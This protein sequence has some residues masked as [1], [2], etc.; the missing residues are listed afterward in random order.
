MS[1]PILLI[2]FD[3][4]NLTEEQVETVKFWALAAAE[5]RD[6]AGDGTDR[7]PVPAV[8]AQ[9]EL[10]GPSFVAVDPAGQASS[11]RLV[12]TGG[13][14]VPPARNPQVRAQRLA[15]LRDA[16]L[17][18]PPAR[19]DSW[20]ELSLAERAVYA[21]AF[22]QALVA[23]GPERSGA[24]EMAAAV[25]HDAVHALRDAAP[26]DDRDSHHAMFRRFR[27][28]RTAKGGGS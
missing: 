2:A 15:A 26:D 4:S 3:L 24:W 25:A 12:S 7:P 17:E 1:T 21:H 28:D 5:E 23:S 13:A 16:I 20:S 11:I 9:L 14:Y 10:D 19:R 27:G 22:A 8:S 18:E 6:G